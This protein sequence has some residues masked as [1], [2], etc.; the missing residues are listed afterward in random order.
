MGMGRLA[1]EKFAAEG[2]KVALLDIRQSDLDQAV[3]ELTAGGKTAKGYRAD[4]S[5]RE[6]IY[7]VFQKIEQDFGPVDILFNNAGVVFGGP[8]LQV[9][10]EKLEQM[11]QINLIAHIWTMKAVLPGMMAKKAGHIIN[12]SSATGLVGVPYLTAYC[13]SKFGVLGMTE[14]LYLE[15]RDQGYKGI[16][17]TVVTPSYVAT[18]MFAGARPPLLSPWVKPE[19]V[20]NKIIKA[21][22]KNRYSVRVPFV[23]HGIPA[24]KALLTI[25]EVNLLSKIIGMSQSM[26]HWTGRKEIK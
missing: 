17:C 8:I 22:K 12:F 20:V 11:I 18:G 1:A 15:L 6:E 3:S 26:H 16:K 5:H 10:D 23:V 25:G 7:G 4:V 9:D 19:K 13:A 24:L 21:V 14:A 2:A